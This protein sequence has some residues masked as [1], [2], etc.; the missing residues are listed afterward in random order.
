MFLNDAFDAA[1]DAR[2]RPERPIPSG[3]IARGTRARARLRDARARRSRSAFVALTGLA[4]VDP[5]LLVAGAAVAA[6]VVVYDRWH[7]GVAWSPVVMGFCRAGLYVMGALAVGTLLDG[8]VLL[9]A[10]SLLLYVVGLDVRRRA[11][12]MPRRVGRVWPTAFL[13][14]PVDR[15]RCLPSTWLVNRRSTSRRLALVLVAHVAWTL[16]ALV[17]ALRG[18]R[19]AI[20]RA[21][22]A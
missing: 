3:R 22:V 6:G 5:G 17:I 16:R 20:P 7:K 1:I 14:A 19:G 21:V 8:A 12:R 15:R 4:T 11:S 10:A 9:P 18:G 2:E 13:F